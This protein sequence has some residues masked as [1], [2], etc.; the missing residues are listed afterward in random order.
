ML[1]E[2]A[3]LFHNYI[4]NPKTQYGSNLL[5]SEKGVGLPFT[6]GLGNGDQ[7]PSCILTWFYQFQNLLLLLDGLGL[8]LYDI[9][10]NLL[11]LLGDELCLFLDQ[12]SLEVEVKELFLYLVVLLDHCLEE[13]VLTL[14][15]LLADLSYF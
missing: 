5:R 4:I 6:Q 13:M 12:G 15:P 2:V 1:R 10:L 7:L 14:C 8:A 3:F 11:N 9:G